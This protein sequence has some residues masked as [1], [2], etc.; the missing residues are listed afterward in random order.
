MAANSRTPLRLRRVV[1]ATLLISGAGLFVLGALSFGLL[2]RDSRRIDLL[3]TQLAGDLT[4]PSEQLRPVLEYFNDLPPTRDPDVY[5]LSPVFRPL[6]RT[7]VQVMDSGG[8]CGDRSRA[9]VVMLHHLGVKAERV[10][11]FDG[12]GNSYHAVARVETERGEYIVDP[13]YGIIYDHQDGAPMDV[14]FIEQNMPEVMQDEFERGN[15]QVVNYPVYRGDYG[16]L[17]THWIDNALLEPVGWVLGLFM[18]EGE[19]RAIPRPY[20]M[21]EPAAMVLSGSF[22]MGTLLLVAGVLLLRRRSRPTP[23]A[24]GRPR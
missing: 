9:L 15:R 14:K 6:R 19:I 21:E 3:V 8:H 17:G 16:R 22:T 24:L 1:A 7:T 4:A 12:Q 2:E 18:N 13:L 10:A 20:I 5:F 11:L 23:L